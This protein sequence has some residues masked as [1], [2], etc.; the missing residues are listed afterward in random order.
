MSRKTIDG[1]CLADMLRGGCAL[2][3]SHADE[4][5]EL[6]VFPVPDGDTGTNM[7]MTLE[8]GVA[9]LSGLDADSISGVSE[10]FARGV[11][12]GARGNSGVILSQMFAGINEELKKHSEADASILSVAFGL[13]VERAYRA[14]Q[15][16]TEGTI[17]TVFRESAEYAASRITDDTTVEEFFELVTEKAKDSL[18]HTVELLPVL[19]E[20]GV[21]DSG[22]AGYLY[23]ALGMLYS[24]NGRLDAENTAVSLGQAPMPDIDSFRRDS[25]LEFGYCTELMLRLTDAKCDPDS[26]EP[27]TVISALESMGGESIVAYKDADLLKIHVHTFAPGNVLTEALKYGE[28]LTVKI[29]NM[30]I[31]HSGAEKPKINRANKPWSVVAVATGDGLESLFTDMGCDVVIKGGQTCNPSAQDFLLAF[32]NASRIPCL[33]SRITKMCLWRQSRRHRSIRRAGYSLCLP[34]TSVRASAHSL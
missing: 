34:R 9:A 26:F 6:N 22:G 18:E 10:C 15:R 16:P 12:L 29:E 32:E 30:S 14:V 11:L 27:G 19:A 2:L 13:G 17:L 8:G 23:M 3:R 28:L 20:A 1:R 24:L 31:G 5:N 7:T 21:V 25:V 4:V 33:C